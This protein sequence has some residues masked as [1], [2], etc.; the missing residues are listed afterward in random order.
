MEHNFDTGA[1]LLIDKPLTWTSFDVVKKLRS[2]IK[3]KKIGHAGTLD[4]LATGLLV[5]CTGKF[6]KK[7]NEI[8]DADKEY[9]CSM[10]VGKT[11][12]S[13][14][15]ETE[16]DGEYHFQHITKEAVLDLFQKNIGEIEQVPPVYSAIKIDGKR[17]YESA[18][19]GIE[20]EIKSRLVTLK[21]IEL[22]TFDLPLI[23]FRVVCTKGTYIRSLVRDWGLDLGSGAYMSALRRTK[24]GDLSVENAKDI[25]LLTDEIRSAREAREALEKAANESENISTN[26]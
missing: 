4:P 22:I 21:E 26:N 17:A 10:V 24:I 3:M 9:I 23:E 7:I 20:V 12:P 13:V 11:T 18:R 16:F 1:V 6:T 19:K 15:L 14:D 2:A 25:I 5:V 8:Q